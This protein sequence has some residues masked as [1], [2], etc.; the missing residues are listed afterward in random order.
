MAG[1]PRGLQSRCPRV[2]WELGSIPRR[3]RHFEIPVI[4][5]D[6]SIYGWENLFDPQRGFLFNILISQVEIV[7]Y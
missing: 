3:S 7:A 6:F 4:S 5:R 1:A 2:T